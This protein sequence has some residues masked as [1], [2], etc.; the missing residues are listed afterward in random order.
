[1]IFGGFSIILVILYLV[2]AM[3]VAW[4]LVLWIVVGHRWLAL[5]PRQG[6]GRV[7]TSP[8]TPPQLPDR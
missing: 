2:I 3:A 6:S 7:S 8:E 1:M 4:A 5:H